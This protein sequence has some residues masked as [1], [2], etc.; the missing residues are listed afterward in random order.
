MRRAIVLVAVLGVVLLL[1][2]AWQYVRLLRPNVL[3]QLNPD[4]VRLLNELPNVDEPNK[5]VMRACLRM[6]ACL[7]PTSAV[8]V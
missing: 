7:T 8:T 4:V 1:V 6:A 5:A 2:T 3:K